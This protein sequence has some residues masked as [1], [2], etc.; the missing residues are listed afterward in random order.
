M[1]AENEE[2]AAC[3]ARLKIT[4]DELA[5]LIETRNDLA[6]GKLQHVAPE[7]FNIKD[8]DRNRKFNMRVGY[9]IKGCGTV[10]CIGGDM[11][12]RLN[13]P[14]FGRSSYVSSHSSPAL[15]PL[16][17]PKVDNS[18]WGDITPEQAVKA[19]DNFLKDGNPRWGYVITENT[20]E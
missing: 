12:A 5:A 4:Q 10:C 16:F 3:A 20:N 1:T 15:R 13:I 18:L 2:A 7:H 6:T 8:S 17:Y 9:D 19:I 14:Y 11:S